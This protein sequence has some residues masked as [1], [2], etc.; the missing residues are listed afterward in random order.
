MPKLTPYK[1]LEVYNLAKKLVLAS[2]ELTQELPS[3]E[4]TNFCRYIR[5]AALCVHFNITR[6][7]NENSKK[8]KKYIRASRKALDI[9]DAGCEIM[10][11]VGLAKKE[12]VKDLKNLSSSCYQ[13]L[14][15]PKVLSLY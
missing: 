11:E 13:L 15:Q 9:I 1:D 4:K 2:Y 3:E 12:Q 10:V 14:N 6:A 7:A 8:K 5:T